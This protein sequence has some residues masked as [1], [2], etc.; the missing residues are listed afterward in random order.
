MAEKAEKEK[1]PP[2]VWVLGKVGGPE[3]AAAL[4]DAL[5]LIDVSTASGRSNVVID[6]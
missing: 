4:A 6:L 5:G 1:A 3:L 2:K